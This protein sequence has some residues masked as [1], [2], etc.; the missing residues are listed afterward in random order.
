MDINHSDLRKW[1]KNQF[2][3]C[4][5]LSSNRHSASYKMAGSRILITNFIW[6]K[7]ES[8]RSLL[9]AANSSSRKSENRSYVW[10]I[11]YFKRCTVSHHQK[12]EGEYVCASYQVLSIRLATASIKF[13]KLFVFSKNGY[14]F[15]WKKHSN[16]F[17]IRYFFFARQRDVCV[18]YTR[19]IYLFMFFLQNTQQCEVVPSIN[20]R[21]EK[22]LDHKKMLYSYFLQP[23]LEEG[24]KCFVRHFNVFTCQFGVVCYHRI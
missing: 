15:S 1:V 17:S 9:H 10:L 14:C 6:Q 12:K 5:F 13:I 3:I 8:L 7:E 4:F 23:L 19:R 22:V 18:I 20:A 21:A 2:Q 11:F 16:Y 24:I